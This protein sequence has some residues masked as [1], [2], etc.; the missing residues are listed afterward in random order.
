MQFTQTILQFL[1]LACA[2]VAALRLLSTWKVD[3]VGAALAFWFAS[4][5]VA[6]ITFTRPGRRTDGLVDGAV[7]ERDATEMYRAQYDNFA[8]FSR[9]PFIP[10]EISV[11]LAERPRR[12]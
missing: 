12:E 6:V 1:A 2:I 7:D 11:L 3:W 9:A 8:R 4:F 5:T 10:A